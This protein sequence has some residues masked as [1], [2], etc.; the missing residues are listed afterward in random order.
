[1]KIDTVALKAMAA[2]ITYMEIDW[3]RAERYTPAKLAAIEA[4]YRHSE[5]MFI[6][7]YEQILA[8]RGG[9]SYVEQEEMFTRIEQ[10][11]WMVYQGLEVINRIRYI[12]SLTA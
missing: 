12:N 8:G 2:E 5:V 10:E 9:Y 7:V 4:Q 3:D 11:L 6:S 1:M